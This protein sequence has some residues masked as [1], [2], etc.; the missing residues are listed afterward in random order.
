MEQ[1]KRPGGTGGL[2]YYTAWDKS[3]NNGCVYC[4]KPA[5]TREHVPS[6]VFLDDP[7]PENLATIP[8][9]FECNNGFSAD[10]KY[11]ACFLDVLKEAVYQNYTLRIATAQRIEKSPKLKA[12]LSDEIKVVDGQVHYSYDEARLCR[13]FVKLAKGHA[14]F[15]FDHINFDDSNISI[16]YNFAFNMSKAELSEFEEIPEMDLL[17]EVGSRSCTSPFIVQ[18]IETGKASAFM[19]WNDVQ[20]GQYRYQ[21]SENGTGGI[22]VKIVIYEMLYCRVDLD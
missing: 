15:E 5:E 11:V 20:E 9:C 22:C 3:T 18:N 2:G 21:V 8:A 6:K 16:R 4:G 7:Y 10:E 17:P 19:F 1:R 12:L 14:G 13:I